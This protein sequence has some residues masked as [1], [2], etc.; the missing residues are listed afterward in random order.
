M[1]ANTAGTNLLRCIECS[2]EL[3]DVYKHLGYMKESE[4]NLSDED[5]K[6]LSRMKIRVDQIAKEKLK[7]LLPSLVAADWG[8]PPSFRC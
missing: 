2:H 6:F 4:L 1:F 8:T 7:E 3:D 5:R